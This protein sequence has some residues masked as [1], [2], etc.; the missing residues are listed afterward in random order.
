MGFKKRGFGFGKYDGFGGKLKAGESLLQA[1]LR[2]LQEE[3]SLIV[4]P[5]DLNPMGVIN[6][7]FPYKPVWDQLVHL[8]IAKKWHGVPTESEEMR[9][10]WFDTTSLPLGKMWDDAQYWMPYT[11]HGQPIQATFILNQDNETVKEY[12]IQLL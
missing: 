11:L 2:E 3:S 1:A 9:P 8:Y 4:E 7:V 10:E 6:F 12:T 5:A